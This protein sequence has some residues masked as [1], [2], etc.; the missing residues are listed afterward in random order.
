[1]MA[2]WLIKLVAEARNGLEG[3]IVRNAASLWGTTIVTSLFG[4]AYWF[5]AARMVPARAVG[6]ASAVQSAAQFLSFFCVLGL[7]TLLISELSNDKSNRRSLMLTAATGSGLFA[8]VV[9]GIVGV[10]LE[11]LSSA[12]RQGLAGLIGLI[13]FASLSA[14]TTVLLVLDDSCIGLLR[15]DLQLRRNTVFAVSKLLFLPV[16]ITVWPDRS[17][18]ELQVAWLAGL[19]VS[20]VFLVPGLANLTRGQSSRLD[21]RRVFAKRRL[22]LGHHWLNLSVQ[23]PRLLI[24]VLVAVILGPDANA[25]FTAASLAVGFVIVV[26]AHLSTVLFA[27]P[28]GMKRLFTAKS[29]KRCGFP[30]WWHFSPPPFS[31]FSPASFSRYS[32]RTMR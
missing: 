32:V 16:L 8:L 20:L 24:P 30:W 2:P 13:V 28:P 27:L 9:S 29:G 12:L 10:G 21:F 25:A 5:V 19:A 15:G 31:P 14:L 11:T 1:M 18:T 6:V 4:F 26:P 22:M 23:S 3:P 7:S 17:G